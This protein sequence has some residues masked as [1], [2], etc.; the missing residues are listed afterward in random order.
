[1]TVRFEPYRSERVSIVLQNP[2]PGIYVSRVSGHMDIAGAR[3][4][5]DGFERVAA[6]CRPVEAFHDWRGMEGYDVEAREL[7]VRWSASHRAD[8]MRVHI[9]LR[10]KL[11]AMAV[12]VARIKLP[13]LEAYTD[14]KAFL[15]RKQEAIWKK[16]GSGAGKDTSKSAQ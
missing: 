6:V 10:S 14:E 2:A 7:L 11:V 9:L 1:M 16:L 4:L 15:D 5:I 8:V 3:Y 13:Y 12:A